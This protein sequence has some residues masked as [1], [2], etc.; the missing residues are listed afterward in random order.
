[1]SACCAMIVRTTSP[2]L[3][4]PTSLPAS[5]YGQMADA[6][7]V[8]ES[9]AFCQGRGRLDIDHRCGHD[10]AHAC[11]LRCAVLEDDLARVVAL[12]DDAD[13]MRILDDEECPDLVLVHP[14]DRIVDR[15]VGPI[16]CTPGPSAR[17]WSG[18]CRRASRPDPGFTV[19]GMISLSL[20]K[21]STPVSPCA[22]P[23]TSNVLESSHGIIHWRWYA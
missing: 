15:C 9:H 18:P 22:Q 6:L 3:T 19:G 7:V 14:G 20:H 10:L 16:V 23:G 4:T 11:L 5:I 17:G 2:M 21:H 13:E 8:D 1:V 12:G